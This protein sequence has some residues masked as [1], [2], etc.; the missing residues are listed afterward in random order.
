[1]SSNDRKNPDNIMFNAVGD[2][3]FPEK[4]HEKE[5]YIRMNSISDPTDSVA[6]D[7]KYHRRC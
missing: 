4:L 2:K 5:F 6:N 3:M 1:M 7:V